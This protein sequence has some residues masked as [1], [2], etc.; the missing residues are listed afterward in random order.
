MQVVV[1]AAG[2]GSRL[3]ALTADRPTGLVAVA[4]RPLLAH[5]VDRAIGAG[6]DELV[7]VIGYE[8]TRIVD[9]FGDV[10]EGT[11]ITYVHQRERRGLA[12]AVLQAAPHV[13][14]SFLVVNGDNVFAESLRPVVDA[15]GRSGVDGVLAE[16]ILKKDVREDSSVRSLQRKTTG[17][18]RRYYSGRPENRDNRPIC[19][20]QIPNRS[21][22]ERNSM[23]SAMSRRTIRSTRRWSSS[24]ALPQRCSKE[25]V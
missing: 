5:V 24:S 8:G 1:P 2:R 11:P 3:G 4:G 10:Y 17:R 14:G 18:D 19:H 22:D 15:L 6:A 13:S 23:P 16:A 9:R 12:H 20:R 21:P 25:S 7:V